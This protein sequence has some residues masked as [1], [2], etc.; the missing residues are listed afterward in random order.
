M[1]ELFDTRVEKIRQDMKAGT[2]ARKLKQR[3][4][5]AEA[6]IQ[7]AKS[8]LRDFETKMDRKEGDL[9]EAL[10]V[11]DDELRKASSR[12]GRKRTADAM[13]S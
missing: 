12:A 3:V 9:G 6:Y 7:Q 8:A 11:V 2:R 4:A 1:P 10:D 13:T 5:E